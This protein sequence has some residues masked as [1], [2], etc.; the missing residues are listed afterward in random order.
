M[1]P[2]SEVRGLL[3]A[4][5]GTMCGSVRRAGEGDDGKGWEERGRGGYHVG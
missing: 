1:G 4:L 5:G 2:D 3:H